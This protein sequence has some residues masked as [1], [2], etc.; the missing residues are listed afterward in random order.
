MSAFVR[1][2]LL[3]AVAGVCAPGPA[4]AQ[5]PAA[6]TAAAEGVPAATKSQVLQRFRVLVIREHVFE[7]DQAS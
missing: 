6:A 7:V 4:R 5:P 1:F 2:M 3:L